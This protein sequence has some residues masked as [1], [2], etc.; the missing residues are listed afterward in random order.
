MTTT[1][2]LEAYQTI[3]PSFPRTLQDATTVVRSLGIRYLWV[4]AFY[5]IQ[6]NENNKAKELN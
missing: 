1:L 4:N 2:N 3:I 5:I 6:D